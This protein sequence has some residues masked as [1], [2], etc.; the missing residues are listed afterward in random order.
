MGSTSAY[1][2]TRSQ[3]AERGI[4]I[5]SYATVS[6]SDNDVALRVAVAGVVSQAAEHIAVRQ[7]RNLIQPYAWEKQW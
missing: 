3:V 5:A 4:S 1:L 6:D 7:A 2:R